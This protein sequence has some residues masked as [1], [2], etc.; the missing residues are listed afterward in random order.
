M[1]GAAIMAGS[2]PTGTLAAPWTIAGTGDFNGD[3]RADILWRNQTNG[4]DSIWFMNGVAATGAATTTMLPTWSVAGVADFNND[5]KADITWRN[6][7][8]GATSL[9]LMNGAV[10]VGSANLVPAMAAPW[11]VAR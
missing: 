1:N 3:G 8:N 11:G 9:W 4:L 6:L 5:G 7:S 2:G 10:R